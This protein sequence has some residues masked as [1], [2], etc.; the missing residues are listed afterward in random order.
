MAFFDET[1]TREDKTH[2]FSAMASDIGL[3]PGRW[4]V[5]IYTSLGN[6][7]TTVQVG[8]KYHKG[9]LVS[10]LYKQSLGCIKIEVFND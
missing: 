10:V 9:E 1:N 6:G 7:S 8:R 5:D 2:E 4:P 3:Q